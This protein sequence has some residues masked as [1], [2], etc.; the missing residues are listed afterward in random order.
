[1]NNLKTSSVEEAGT[2]KAFTIAAGGETINNTWAA[3]TTG[4]GALLVQLLNRTDLPVIGG[5]AANAVAVRVYDAASRSYVYKVVATAD[6]ILLNATQLAT[7]I[8]TLSLRN[9]DAQQEIYAAIQSGDAATINAVMAKY[10]PPLYLVGLSPDELAQYNAITGTVDL[11]RSEY[12][13]AY[14]GG[15][16]V[17]LSTRWQ[18]S[19]ATYS[20]D[21]AAKTYSY[22][23]VNLGEGAVWR[24]QDRALARGQLI[25]GGT[26][27]I[28]SYWVTGETGVLPAKTIDP[29]SADG[30]L[31]PTSDS[32]VTSTVAQGGATPLNNTSTAIAVKDLTTGDNSVIDLSWLNTASIGGAAPLVLENNGGPV[33]SGYTY[34]DSAGNPQDAYIYLSRN[35]YVDTAT[36]GE[37]TTLRLGVYKD[38]NGVSSNDAVYIADARQALAQLASGSKTNLYIQLGW[39]PDV[40]TKPFGEVLYKPTTSSTLGTTTYNAL[41]LGI[42]DGAENFT[43]TGQK[44][45]ADGIFSTYEITPYLGMAEN[46]FTTAASQWIYK[47]DGAGHYLTYGGAVIMNADGT[48]PF[49]AADPANLTAAERTYLENHSVQRMGYDH[50]QG[51]AWYLEG[52][53][54]EDTGEV[55]QSG[56]TAADNAVI[57]NNV[58]K[59]HY[60]NLFRRS[61]SVR[62]MAFAGRQAAP[63]NSGPRFSVSPLLPQS[64][65]LEQALN[66]A[67]Q[68]AATP[69]RE[70]VWAEVFRGRFDSAGSYGRN[71]GQ[72]YSG[73]QVGFDKLLDKELH[74]GQVRMGFYLSQSDGTSHTEG[75]SG[76]QD[77]LGSGLYATW[78]G[79]A[80]HYLDAGLTAVKLNQDYR[81]WGN[82]GA[83]DY[84]WVKG[85]SSTWG[86]GLGLQYGKRN[87]MRG[88]Y[89][90]P[91]ASFFAGHVD[92]AGYTLGNGLEISQRGIDTATG[93]LG[94]TVGKELD[95][96]R[97]SLYAG[98]SLARE[99]AGGPD[100][101]QRYGTQSKLVEPAGD[102][103]QWWEFRLGGHAQLSPDSRLNLDLMKTTGSDRS[104]E[105]RVSGGLDFRF[106]GI[107]GGNAKDAQSVAATDAGDGR[108]SA[109]TLILGRPR[110][111]VP[112]AAAS[113]N[114]ALPATAAPGETVPAAAAPGG[115][116]GPDAA[117]AAEASAAAQPAPEPS[118]ADAAPAAGISGKAYVPDDGEYAF[119][120]VTVE[121]PRPAWE[122]ALSPGQVSVIYTDDFRGE[123]K[124]LPELLERVPGLYVQRSSGAGHY[125]VARIRGSS[126]AQVNVYIDGVLMNLNG[127]AAVNLSAIPV[128]NVERVEVYRGY[129]PARFA[130]APIGGVINIVT[131]KPQVGTGHISQ[132][133]K[134]Y[135][136]YS[137]EYQ[138]SMPLGQG[139]LL[140][141][142]GR[143]IWQGDFPFMFRPFGTNS[144][145]DDRTLHRRSNGYQNDNGLLKWQDDHWTVKAAWKSLHEDLP[146]NVTGKNG[147]ENLNT[148]RYDKGYSDSKMDT[149]YKEFSLGR[150]D[151]AG[152]LDWGWRVDYLDS[153]KHYRNTGSYR[154]IADDAARVAS[155][156]LQD[157]NA[158]KETDYLPGRLWSDY[159]SKKWNANL[160]LAWRLDN[161]LLEF[162]GDFSRETMDADGNRWGLS[163]YEASGYIGDRER[164]MLNKYSINEAHFT[165]QDTVTLNTAGD[166]KLTPIFRGDRVDMETMGQN[167]RQWQ[168][169]GGAALQKDLGQGWGLK[170]TWGT[171]NRHPNFYEIFGDGGYIRP[172]RGAAD[173]YDVDN[174]SVWERGT[175]FDFGL[176]WQGRLGAADTATALTWYQRKAKN[177]IVLGTP[178][179]AGPDILLAYFNIDRVDIHG[180]ELTHNMQWQR[181]GLT[182]AATWQQSDSSN[183]QYTGS[184]YTTPISF[185][186]EWVINARVDYRFPGDKLSTFVEYNY[187]DK[188]VLAYTEDATSYQE[189]GLGAYSTWDLGLKYKFDRSWQLSAGVNDLFNQGYDVLA[190][191]GR[192]GSGLGFSAPYPLPGRTYYATMEYK[193]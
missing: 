124:N 27:K 118:R 59:S 39:V 184:W 139:S 55:G 66:P 116:L 25:P 148:W 79:P 5:N 19:Q 42:Y 108:E 122:K 37:G 143:D 165:L 85:D 137:S 73:W 89:W 133:M 52:Y 88:W 159:H 86:Y 145:A 107:G 125:T 192:I 11:T 136:G 58:W 153:Q 82:T 191:T 80:G 4:H 161:H 183:R 21:S 77:S 141:T 171:Y 48:A 149:D 112:V 32:G 98:V 1:M 179:G 131:K 126:A 151:T 100:I 168:W 36:L 68:P 167:D 81:F 45:R 62:D 175:Q 106:S 15:D 169:S 180:V 31:R 65:E 60:L 28:D 46:Y 30:R 9:V 13:I 29:A 56:K 140:A 164:K 94:L 63:A 120:P 109:N 78:Q 43:V 150:R 103:D 187:M 144:T 182:L 189:S 96:G 74:G 185:T 16:W 34:P 147:N 190:Y 156:E 83:G 69:G 64:P 146:M 162:N 193:F 12:D 135:G 152:N 127:E 7:G 14:D 10:L 134:S 160:N 142:F 53:S 101:I 91:S 172:N 117:P 75:G 84:N 132:G 128:D 40:G 51:T 170:T 186:P 102:K 17:Q 110:A 188:Q 123:Q 113:E 50:T 24:P 49:A 92:E 138:Y 177:Q 111:A 95:G 38:N 176:N 23:T 166:L 76:D 105:W 121:A 20:P 6:K 178:M 155:G 26:Y 158:K 154:W 163:D 173:F 67:P 22:E 129:I 41:L 119:A 54:Y 87:P 97:G 93:R 57:L 72:S 2:I 47:T 35:L 70:N 3:R 33:K 104:G 115:S 90:E 61:A 44:S 174:G 157:Q 71:V 130:G 181:L 18:L 8:N 99:F 114:A